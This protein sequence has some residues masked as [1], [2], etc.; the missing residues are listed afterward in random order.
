MKKPFLAAFGLTALCLSL[1]AC[2]PISGPSVSPSP[3]PSATPSISPTPSPLASPNNA[4]V[5]N[6]GTDFS[7][8]YGQTVQLSGSAA[9]AD[10]DLLSLQWSFLEI[11]GTSVLENSDIVNAQTAAAAFQPDRPGN[12]RL[13]LSVSDG[14]ASVNDD[15]LV[16]MHP[17]NGAP[18]VVASSN[19]TLCLPGTSVGF[20]GMAM[21][22]ENDDMSYSL[23][24]VSQPNGSGLSFSAD[25]DF[26]TSGDPMVPQYLTLALEGSYTFRF[27]ANDGQGNV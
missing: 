26:Y 20:S 7:V 18:R 11:P 12:Y 6:A 8:A 24:M 2:P 4:P 9:D 5:I 22:P 21:D 19:V 3:E 27:S 23:T 14:A 16:T 13:Q 10:G 1:L 15:V 17:A 25:T